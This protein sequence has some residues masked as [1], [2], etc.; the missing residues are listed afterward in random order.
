MTRFVVPL[1]ALLVPWSASAAGSTFWTDGGRIAAALDAGEIDG[2]EALWL[3]YLT[4]FEPE[5]LPDSF[6]G[7][8]RPGWHCATGLV[9]AL[10]SSWDSFTPA[11]QS[12]M[13]PRVRPLAAVTPPPPPPPET[14]EDDTCWGQYG[15]HRVMGDHFV[16]EWDGNTVNV[17]TAES[18]LESLEYSW[19]KEVEELGW[20]A[21]N[22][23]DDYL[24]LT[25]I[26]DSEWGGA[27]T[28]VDM[29]NGDLLPYIVASSSSFSD[30]IWA[31][32]MAAHEFN[33]AIQF[34]YSFAHEFWWWEAT[35]TYIEDDVF[36][37]HESWAPYIYGFSQNPWMAMNTNSDTDYDRFM[38]MYGM[39]IF[40][41]YLDQHV[42]GEDIVR[43]TW[44]ATEGSHEQY[45]TTL[46][47]L[48]EELEFDWDEA[49]QGFMVANTVMDYDD[50]EH[51]PPLDIERTVGSLPTD[52][53]ASAGT[54]PESYGQNYIRF[55]TDE[56][57]D[58]EPDLWIEFE[59][60]EDGEW[61]VVLVGSEDDEVVEVVSLELEDGAGEGRLEGFGDF[62]RA[63][64][65]VS[66]TRRSLS[67]FDY[68]WTAETVEALPQQ[69]DDD[70]DDGDDDDDMTLRPGEGCQCTQSSPRPLAGLLPAAVL[71]CLLLL[72]RRS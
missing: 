53:E 7:E 21:P 3:G 29:C 5:R 66:P 50:R 71:G 39:A 22:G 11:Q 30:P 46:E 28:T 19:E 70:D 60:D 9:M 23:S 52:G 20:R 51:Y 2:T 35:A 34:G 1:L 13:A 32:D 37:E 43:Q 38:H 49:Y 18:F 44:A 31:Q 45:T 59:G 55:D 47:D 6:R 54:T 8:P 12:Q 15:E 36:P 64:M 26:S 4:H 40:A 62:D 10:E 41:F 17:G 42:G 56:A 27:Y 14:L 24:M 16:V 61:V 65:V 57:E 25:F 67:A 48:A 69:D 63:Y 72:R 58:D 68:S 33:H